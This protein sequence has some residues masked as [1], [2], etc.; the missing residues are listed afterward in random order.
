MAEVPFIINE[1]TD[2]IKMSPQGEIEISTSD[3]RL[4]G[5]YSLY[6]FAKLSDYPEIE[7]T[8]PI[9]MPIKFTRCSVIITP[10]LIPDI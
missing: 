6:I 7:S 2:I 5:E 4:V 8:S 9:N 10:W 1:G 3:N